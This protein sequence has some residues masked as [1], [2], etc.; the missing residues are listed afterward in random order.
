METISIK[1]DF[2][3]NNS[4]IT[5]FQKKIDYLDKSKQFRLRELKEVVPKE[6]EALK[7]KAKELYDLSYYY[8]EKGYP[9]KYQLFQAEASR[10]IKSLKAISRF[11]KQ[12]EIHLLNRNIREL[13]SR[14]EPLRE[15]RINQESI[16]K[17]IL[18]QEFIKCS[19]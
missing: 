9:S 11:R 17:E 5:K 13:E 3:S 10:K 14:I 19:I 7:E 18:F 15:D 4:Q 16:I 8:R 1:R 2:I 6:R 12:K